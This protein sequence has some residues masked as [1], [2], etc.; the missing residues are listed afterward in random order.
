ELN[1]GVDLKHSFSLKKPDQTEHFTKTLVAEPAETEDRDLGFVKGDIKEKVS[2]V[3]SQESSEEKEEERKE[4][5][6]EDDNLISPEIEEEATAVSNEDELPQRSDY[7][8]RKPGENLNVANEL[9]QE[10]KLGFV[11][12][13]FQQIKSKIKIPRAGGI[14][15]LTFIPAFLLI[16]VA[17][18]LFFVKAS[19]TIFVEP[20]VLERET[21]VIADPNVSEI[22]E[23]KKIIPGKVVEVTVSGSG[24]LAASGTKQIGDPAKGKVIVYNLTNSQVSFS[25]SSALTGSNGL[26]YNLDVGV[27]IASQSSSVGADFTTI[28]K[29]GKSDLVGLTS[30]SIGPEGNL[31]AGTELTVAGYPKSQV[32]AKVE[33]SLSG[34]TSKEVTVVTSDDQKKLKAQVIDELRQKA[35]TDLQSKLTDGKKII[36][37]ALDVL[38]GKYTFNKQVNDQ[39]TEFS[40]SASIRFKG[41]S[42]VE[43][44]LKTIVSKLVVTDIPEN[45]ELNLQDAQTQAD[46]AKVDKDGKLTFRARFRAKLLPKLNTDDL[47]KQI[48]GLSVT[49][50]AEKL[51]ALES[52][53][54]SEIKLYP[55]LP[56]Q[57]SRLPLLPQNIS[58]NV[59]P[60]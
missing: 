33:E 13:V 49:A 38:D 23:E 1:S 22:S 4:A 9:D 44:D 36:P 56:S 11:S 46:V 31:P 28:T 6:L 58:I 10:G 35:V 26:K 41:T 32:V 24:K 17:A 45:Y 47:K 57:I 18:Y 39:A 59:T 20:K 55:N 42:Y 40:L 50:A 53:I 29:P 43:A 21:E 15:K 52:V 16:L 7:L 25:Q 19:V 37:E 30:A 54:G 3:K 8:M 5:E 48:K 51:K 2:S 14:F 34:G 60:K 12:Q 27:K